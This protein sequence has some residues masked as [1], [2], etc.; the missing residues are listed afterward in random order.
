MD[1]REMRVQVRKKIKTPIGGLNLTL[2]GLR[3]I[4]IPLGPITI[5]ISPAGIRASKT[6]SGISLRETIPKEKILSALSWLKRKI[7]AR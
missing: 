1:R 4:S 3:S 7:G 2:R 5:N 6:V